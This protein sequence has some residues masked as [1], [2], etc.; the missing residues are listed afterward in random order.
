MSNIFTPVKRQMCTL[1]LKS[2]NSAVMT[3]CITFCKSSL[4]DSRRLKA[5]HLQLLPIIFFH[6]RINWQINYT[7]LPFCPFDG[8]FLMKTT[9]NQLQWK[10]S[11]LNINF[12][13]KDFNESM[14][15]KL[16]QCFRLPHAVLHHIEEEKLL[17]TSDL[18]D[19]PDVK[20]TGVVTENIEL[21]K[22]LFFYLTFMQK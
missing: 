22:S 9:S 5:R 21:F 6:R 12:F 17:P 3:F 11:L 20:S 4:I 7:F 15:V 8:H 19:A 2:W 14:F 13:G 10:G 1:L 16:R 18:P